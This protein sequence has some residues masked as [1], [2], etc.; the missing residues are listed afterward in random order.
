MLL[1]EDHGIITVHFAGLPPGTSSM[2][3]KFV[4]PETLARFGGPAAFA[5]AVDGALGKLGGLVHDPTAI[6]RLLLGE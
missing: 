2:L 6:R 4:V 3:V 1:L 5:K